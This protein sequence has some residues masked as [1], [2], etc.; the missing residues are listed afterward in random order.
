MVSVLLVDECACSVVRGLRNPADSC[1][2]WTQG[3]CH[4]LLLPSEML[5][6]QA[7]PLEGGA[8]VPGAQHR[9]F[10]TRPRLL[11]CGLLPFLQAAGKDRRAPLRSSPPFSFLS[12]SYVVADIYDH[13]RGHL[14]YSRHAGGMS[15]QGGPVA[16]SKPLLLTYSAPLMLISHT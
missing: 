9:A 10:P 5:P 7:R 2:L 16:F 8:S 6:F 3:S 12:C 1:A 14:L 4:F 11:L 15:F 13:R